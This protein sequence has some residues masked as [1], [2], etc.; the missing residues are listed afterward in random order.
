VSRGEEGGEEGSEV[1]VARGRGSARG[2]ELYIGPCRGRQMPAG[3][4]D[5][6]SVPDVSE[7]GRWTRNDGTSRR[8][9]QIPEYPASALTSNPVTRPWV[10]RPRELET[11]TACGAHNTMSQVEYAVQLEAGSCGPQAPFRTRGRPR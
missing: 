6:W 10:L 9:A 4:S 2:N 3:H 1:G 11:T 8:P 5:L 7:K